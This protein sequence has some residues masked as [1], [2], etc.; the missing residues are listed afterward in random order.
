MRWCLQFQPKTYSATLIIGVMIIIVITFTI[1]NCIITITTIN[2]ITTTITAITINII[3][4]SNSRCERASSLLP[5]T[6]SR[7]QR[8]PAAGVLQPSM[9]AVA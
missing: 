9:A 8:Q 3:T 7:E 1:I 6:R 4:T 5:Q 2:S